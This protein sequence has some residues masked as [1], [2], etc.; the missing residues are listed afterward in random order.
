MG[1]TPDDRRMRPFFETE[2]VPRSQQIVQGQSGQSAYAEMMDLKRA[3]DARARTHVPRAPMTPGAE[4]A[5]A[6]AIE[7]MNPASWP[8]LWGSRELGDPQARN[9]SNP[10]YSYSGSRR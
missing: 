9:Y 1:M 3:A 7:A 4:A 10:Y 6:M 5:R 2:D 8:L